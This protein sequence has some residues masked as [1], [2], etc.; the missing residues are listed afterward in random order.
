MWLFNDTVWSGD[1]I[2]FEIKNDYIQWVY[3]LDTEYRR[4]E[5][6]GVPTNFV[7][8]TA[9][10][11]LSLVKYHPIE[12]CRLYEACQKHSGKL[13][14]ET[15]EWMS[16]IVKTT[17]RPPPRW[18]LKH[19]KEKRHVCETVNG[20]DVYVIRTYLSLI[21]SC[22][23]GRAENTK[24]RLPHSLRHAKVDGNGLA[25]RFWSDVGHSRC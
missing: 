10:L 21:I 8:P 20:C 18:L 15:S 13:L 16:R 11:E 9:D 1:V 19:R 5:I 12:G 24:L 3:K 4:S 17:L 25:C 6:Q 7:Y 23:A 22:R 14:P 2:R